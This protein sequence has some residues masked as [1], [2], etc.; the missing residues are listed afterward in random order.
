MRDIWE[1]DEGTKCPPL[2]RCVL[3]LLAPRWPTYIDSPSPAFLSD[4]SP[5]WPALSLNQTVR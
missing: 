5:E 4:V 1:G 2:L 3:V